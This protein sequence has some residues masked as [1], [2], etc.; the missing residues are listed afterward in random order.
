MLDERALLVPIFE[1]GFMFGNTF[2]ESS[3]G[4]SII[5]FFT[6]L[7]SAW[8]FVDNAV[9]WRMFGSLG[10][11]NLADSGLGRRRYPKVLANMLLQKFR[12]SRVRN[13]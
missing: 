11:D 9:L 8:D 10:F 2:L 7:V 1:G 4:L 6:C 12:Q 13:Y 5:S 3:V